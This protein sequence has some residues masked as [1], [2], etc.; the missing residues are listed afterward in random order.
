MRNL[1]ET[2]EQKRLNE[3]GAEGPVEE[4]GSLSIGAPMGDGTRG[5]QRQ[6]RRMELLQPRSGA[7][8]R[9]PLGRGRLGRLLRREAAAVLRAR[10]ME[11]ARFDH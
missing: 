4:V 5:L 3:A 9:L 7:F 10:P 2:A 8:A 6:W 1:N 11:R